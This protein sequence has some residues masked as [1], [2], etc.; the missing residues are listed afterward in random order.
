MNVEQFNELYTPEPFSGCWLWM[1]AVNRG[2]YGTWGRDKAHR[3]SWRLHQGDIPKGLCVLH[4]CDVR[5]C[6]NPA[7]LFIGT[8][9]DN[10]QD[11]I[12]KGRV[13]YANGERHGS[14][15]LTVAQVAEIRADRRSQRQIAASYGVTQQNI[16]AIKQGKTWK[17]ESEA[18]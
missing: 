9:A 13:V 10:N 7:H 8:I 18:Q 11:A 2:G 15:K 6:V 1:G 4:K 5:A 14:S 3:V 17:C 16:F 12:N